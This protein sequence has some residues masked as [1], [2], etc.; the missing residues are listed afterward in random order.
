MYNLGGKDQ[1]KE[2]P[3]DYTR[4]TDET[5]REGVIQQYSM[6]KKRMNEHGF[7]S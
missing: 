5:E 4:P 7:Y 3:R 6:R 1:H 2:S